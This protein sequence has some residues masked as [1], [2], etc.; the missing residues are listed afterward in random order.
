M[1]PNTIISIISTAPT[2]DHEGFVSR[3]DVII[4]DIRAYKEIKSATEKAMNMAQYATSTVL[5]QFRRIP[6]VE[7]NT[8]NIISDA[9]GRYN[10]ISV[11]T[12]SSRG[13]YVSCVAEKIEGS[14]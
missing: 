7:V 14:G 2:K 10:I 6:K 13:L 3:D 8:A 1:R 9:D 4:A 5:F 12:I 11:D